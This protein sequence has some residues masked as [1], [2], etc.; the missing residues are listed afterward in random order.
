MKAFIVLAPGKNA[1]QEEIDA[2]CRENLA[3][4]KV[5]RLYE[6]REELPKTQIGKVLRRELVREEKERYAAE[7]AAAS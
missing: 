5:P 2:Y 3:P 4:Y 7:Q 1:T 6:F